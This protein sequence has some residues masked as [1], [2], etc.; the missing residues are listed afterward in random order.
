MR[1]TMAAWLC[2]VCW[3]GQGSLDRPSREPRVESRPREA[4]AVGPVAD[5]EG[6]AAERHAPG[7]PSVPRLLSRG[8]PPAVP[9]L[10][11]P[12]VLV[13]FDAMS[14]RG[15]RAD[16]AEERAEVVPLRGDPDPPTTVVREAHVARVP[17][18]GS[19]AHPDPV[20]GGLELPVLPVDRRA[21]LPLLLGAEAPAAPGRSG[22]EEVSADLRR[23]PAVAPAE[24]P[25][26]AVASRWE[27]GHDG[28]PSEPPSYEVVGARRMEPHG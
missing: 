16:V 28:Q 6:L 18:P 8:G 4:E 17:A 25:R 12:V 21:L 23:S 11:V 9:G 19:Q 24:P 20:L 26:D 10:V 7:L 1:A 15:S 27:P 5:A 13:A 2:L 3:L 14:G 22:P